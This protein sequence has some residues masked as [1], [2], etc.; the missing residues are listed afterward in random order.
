MM[1]KRWPGVPDQQ[2]GRVR[3]V[4]LIL[5]MAGLVGGCAN[6]ELPERDRSLACELRACQCVEPARQFWR[7]DRTID[8]QW[9]EEGRA[10]CPPGFRLEVLPPKT[11]S[12]R[13]S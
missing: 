12:G 8:V 7:A 13:P 3:A 4:V 11:K 10:S 1:F 2:T 9:S 6:P 5:G